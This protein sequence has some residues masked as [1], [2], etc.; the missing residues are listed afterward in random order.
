VLNAWIDGVDAKIA[1]HSCLGAGYGNTFRTV[2]D[3]LPRVLE[4]W[5]EVKVQQY[6]LDFALRDMVD[7]HALKQLEPD[8]EVQAGVIDIRSLYIET[9]DE[10]VR[11]IHK[12]LEYIEPERVYLTT[13]CGL[14]ALPRFV[15]FEKLKAL[16][17]AANRV[18]A[19]LP[20]PKVVALHGRREVLL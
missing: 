10:I 6:A 11:R 19:E 4:R 16:V 9:D 1:W 2:E 3:A 12:V 5:Q 17:R 18:R 13:D 8:R 7:V 15:A 14:K 20:A